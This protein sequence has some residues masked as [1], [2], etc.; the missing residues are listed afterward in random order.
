MI[1]IQ[2]QV[3]TEAQAKDLKRLGI[4]QDSLFYWLEGEVIEKIDTDHSDWYP[5]YSAFTAAELIV[6][7]GNSI[8]IKS[9]IE[10][11][12]ENAF[13]VLDSLNQSSE[14][15]HFAHAAAHRLILEIEKNW[16]SIEIINKRL[17]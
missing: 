3:C 5:I 2:H 13:Y 12:G 9:Y 11:N 14:F 4:K 10:V 1:P 15:K 7:L 17:S 16:T 8:P 6:L